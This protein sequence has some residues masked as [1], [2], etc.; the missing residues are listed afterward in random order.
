MSVMQD[1]IALEGNVP[2]L[3]D[4]RENRRAYQKQLERRVGVSGETI[5]RSV[6]Y[7]LSTGFLKEEAY[8]EKVPNVRSWL[9]LTELGESVADCLVECQRKLGAISKRTENERRK[10]HA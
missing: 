1:L 10:G 9:V 4:I 3:L 5:K 2:I 8:D 7:L 6:E